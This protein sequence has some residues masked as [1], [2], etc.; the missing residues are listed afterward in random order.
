M[1]KSLKCEIACQRAE[2][3]EYSYNPINTSTGIGR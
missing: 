2:I 1:R 3:N